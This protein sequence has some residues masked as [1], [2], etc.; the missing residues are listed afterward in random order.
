MK[1]NINHWTQLSI[2][3]AIS[4]VIWIIYFGFIRQS[5]K[6]YANPTESFGKM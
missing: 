4:V 5:R 6:E 3:Y 1:K 2:E